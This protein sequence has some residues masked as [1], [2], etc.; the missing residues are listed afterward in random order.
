MTPV[1]RPVSPWSRG[2]GPPR[3]DEDR[4]DL[5][6]SAALTGGDNRLRQPRHL[7]LERRDTATQVNGVHPDIDTR[8]GD[9]NRP[10]DNLTR[11]V[12]EVRDRNVR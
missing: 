4:L 10:R 1:N 3:T 11:D 5:D 8:R 7:P 12:D 6:D 9:G 2:A